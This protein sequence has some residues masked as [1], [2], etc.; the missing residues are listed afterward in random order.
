MHCD[1]D[2]KQV[3]AI[4]KI[5]RSHTHLDMEPFLEWD[6]KV[7]PFAVSW[8]DR[9]RDSVPENSGASVD[10]KKLSAIY[11]F[12][13]ALP[14]MF[15]PPERN[16]TNKRQIRKVLSSIYQFARAVPFMFVPSHHKASAGR[17]IGDSN[18]KQY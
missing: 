5:L 17:K 8:F 1:T 6:L 3:V 12:S 16:A 2:R 18:W 14:M 4:Q 7:L 15:V 9:A 13:K 11:Q 10:T